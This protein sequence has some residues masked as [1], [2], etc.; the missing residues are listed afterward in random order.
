MS[1]RMRLGLSFLAI[2]LA[3]VVLGSYAMYAMADMNQAARS[4]ERSTIKYMYAA[5][6]L[7][8]KNGE[9]R[10]ALWKL[11]AVENPD[12]A[13][14]A[15]KMRQE[16]IQSI[17]EQMDIISDCAFPDQV[18]K[19]RSTWDANQKIDTTVRQLLSEG[20]RADA[21]NYCASQASHFVD[22]DNA[23]DELSAMEVERAK[24]STVESDSVYQQAKYITI[25]IIIITILG[26]IAL[27]YYF[28]HLISNFVGEFLRVSSKVHDGD[29]TESIKYVSTDEFG[30]IAKSYNETLER[31]RHLTRSIRDIASQ[32]TSTS[33]EISTSVTESSSAT[34]SIANSINEIAGLAAVEHTEMNGAADAISHVVTGMRDVSQLAKDT[35]DKAYNVGNTVSNGIVQINSISEQMNNIE[36]TVGRSAKRVDALGQRSDEIG[37]IVET[38]V[39]ISGQTNLL[40]LNAA[41]EA[42]RAGEH[43]RGFSVV[44]EE[45]RKLAEESQN[46]AQHI[47]ELISTIQTETKNS[48]DV[49]HQG[50]EDVR[51]GSASVQKSIKEFNQVSALVQ[52]MVA[53]MEQV[54]DHIREVTVQ[55][56]RVVTSV[57]SV[58]DKS[59]KV[60]AETEQVSAATE[61]QAAAMQEMARESESLAD[62][63]KRLLEELKIFRL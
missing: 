46:A 12:Q 41:I 33:E 51:T 27:G 32:M 19:I 13:S 26:T 62:L 55:S 29:M 31:L 6:M 52:D 28:Y 37:Q 7:V 59:N 45:I 2:V 11:M 22:M 5:D 49:M 24:T 42:A 35:A 60:S 4:A 8:A 15:E 43:G 10:A 57:D 38:I 16:A 58:Q 50:Q 44:A 63:A 30:N 1:I 21:V 54:A 53:Q 23:C 48:V 47:A 39:N 18:A 20:R 61:E 3:V 40:A 17:N 14:S 9:F 25:A 36:A 34:T 56:D